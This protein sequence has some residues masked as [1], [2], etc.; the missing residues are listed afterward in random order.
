MRMGKKIGVQ[1]NGLLLHYFL[2]AEKLLYGAEI[3]LSRIKL[4]K[5]IKIRILSVVLYVIM[6][7]A[8]IVSIHFVVCTTNSETSSIEL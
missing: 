7:L 4:I 3:H 2:T 5:S 1:K 6:L 8:V